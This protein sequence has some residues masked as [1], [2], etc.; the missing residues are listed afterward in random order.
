MAASANGPPLNAW[1]CDVEGKPTDI[2]YICYSNKVF[3]LVSQTGKMGTII[4]VRP[5]SE[6]DA[7][8]SAEAQTLIG[9]RTDEALD[10][11]ARRVYETMCAEANV[12]LVL[13]LSLADYSPASLTALIAE[14]RRASNATPA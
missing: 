12:P 14:L 3:V 13:S 11:Y 8:A 7:G 9:H 5:P 10:V 1:R 4:H 6:L 2:V